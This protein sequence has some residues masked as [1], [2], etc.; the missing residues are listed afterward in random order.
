MNLTQI[1]K[2][3]RLTQ[4][5]ADISR[6]S[7]TEITGEVGLLKLDWDGKHYQAKYTIKRDGSHKRVG[8]YSQ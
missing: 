2:A 4:N 8:K 1:R 3:S 5:C 6:V 7:F